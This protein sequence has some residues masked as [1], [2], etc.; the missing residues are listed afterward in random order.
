M[1]GTNVPTQNTQPTNV[2]PKQN[3]PVNV[4][5]QNPPPKPVQD[6]NFAD[7]WA[8]SSTGQ[9]QNK[10]VTPTNPVV[11]PP[12]NKPNNPP[13]NPPPRTTTFNQLFGLG[14]K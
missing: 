11:V 3:P 5:V 9:P 6:N 10:P 13:P 8:N 12:Q 14:G 1:F 2:T 4:P 7:I